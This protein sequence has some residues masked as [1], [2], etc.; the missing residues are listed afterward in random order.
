MAYLNLAK[1]SHVREG[2]NGEARTISIDSKYLL[3][4]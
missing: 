4:G 2:R 3:L 1:A